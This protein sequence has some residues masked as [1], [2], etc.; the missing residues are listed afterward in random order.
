MSLQQV[1][2]ST[3]R[4][5]RSLQSVPHI[6][7]L[8]LVQGNG[9]TFLYQDYF[10]RQHIPARSFH[11]PSVSSHSLFT[12]SLV[13]V[14]LFSSQQ[15]CFIISQNKDLLNATTYFFSRLNKETLRTHFQDLLA[16][17]IHSIGVEGVQNVTEFIFSEYCDLHSLNDCL[18]NIYN[19]RC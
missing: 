18:V 4:P 15:E 10:Y 16:K 13:L 8:V 5:N 11:N 14:S 19:V 9:T 6:Y 1:G 17:L 2:L 7:A 12:I 3:Y